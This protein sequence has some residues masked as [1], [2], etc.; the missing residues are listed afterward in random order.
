MLVPA[1]VASDQNSRGG[2]RRARVGR[3]LPSS[4]KEEAE[5]ASAKNK[6]QHKNQNRKTACSCNENKLYLLVQGATTG[7]AAS[8]ATFFRSKNNH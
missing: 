6:I 1:L 4:Q 3:P 5:K 7:Q 8:L 2:L